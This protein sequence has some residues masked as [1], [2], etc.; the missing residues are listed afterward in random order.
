MLL[1]SEQKCLLWLSN[2]EIAARRAQELMA[3][4]GGAQGVWDA[5]G[6]REGPRFLAGAQELLSR[7]H[8]VDAIDGLCEK[9]TQKNVHLLFQDDEAYPELLS[10]IPD[11][12]YLLYYAGK[13]ECLARTCVAVVGTRLS[14]SYG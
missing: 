6:K 13:L 8:S 14:S 9:L 4:Y 11:P 1:T 12:P 7:L 2:G 5:F 10:A 3:V